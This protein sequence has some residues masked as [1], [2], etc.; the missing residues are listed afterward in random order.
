[1]WGLEQGEE[2]VLKNTRGFT[3]IEL[4]IVMVIIGI[5]AAIAVPQFVSVKTKSFDSEAK[6]DLR[7][8]IAAQ[9]VYFADAQAYQTVSVP[10]SGRVDF[11]GDG[12]HDY[13]ASAG[14]TVVVTA[15]TDG[16]QVT[17]K[18]NSSA[19]TWC[20]NNSATQNAGS[21]GAI[22]KTTSC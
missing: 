4:L 3:L 2:A 9:E 12:K 21:P 14:V 22:L 17:A 19:N 8:M 6:S 16:M 15:Y 1:M 11:N 13:Q 7:N 20:V 5:L 10:T 18:H